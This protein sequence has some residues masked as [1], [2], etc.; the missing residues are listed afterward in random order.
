M[1]REVRKEVRED[2]SREG[3]ICNALQVSCAREV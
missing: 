2:R 3:D 1:G